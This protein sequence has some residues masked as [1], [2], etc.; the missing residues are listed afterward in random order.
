MIPPCATSAPV[1]VQ[2]LEGSGSTV[3]SAVGPG[4]RNRGLD[5]RLQSHRIT[6]ETLVLNSVADVQISINQSL[7]TRQYDLTHDSKSN[8]ADA[9]ILI[10]AAKN[11]GCSA[12]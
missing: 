4:C 3:A 6:A 5:R 11:P 1:F 9:Q 12:Q 2:F 10:H 8:V 7:G